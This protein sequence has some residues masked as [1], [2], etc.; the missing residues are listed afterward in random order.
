[1]LQHAVTNAAE[2]SAV[3]YE[4]MSTNRS[5][6]SNIV[7][8]L[9]QEAL[10]RTKI[11]TSVS[12]PASVLSN[13]T[14]KQAA[15][16]KILLINFPMNFDQCVAYEKVYGKPV[17][18]LFHDV[19]EYSSGSISKTAGVEREH[20]MYKENV[21]PIV[22]HYRKFLKVKLVNINVNA[23]REKH[24]HHETRNGNNNAIVA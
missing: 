13:G 12:V 5:V 7:M 1:L 15:V 24:Q 11:S 18:I 6:P 9:L 22:E 21:L 8:T 2:Y 3:I 20:S 16:R 17:E 10:L 19:E 4:Y 23:D 14:K